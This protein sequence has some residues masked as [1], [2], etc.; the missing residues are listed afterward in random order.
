MPA[1]AFCKH[2]V[3]QHRHGKILGNMKYITTTTLLVLICFLSFGQQKKDS[4]PPVK[5]IVDSSTF[6]YSFSA[7][8]QDWEK[9]FI[10]LRWSKATTGDQL[11]D[12]IGE[13]RKNL[14]LINNPKPTNK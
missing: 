3:H 14:K 11:E 7:Q 5:Q 1:Q 10:V 12:M 8:L 2:G 13:I 6:V 4:I 9:L